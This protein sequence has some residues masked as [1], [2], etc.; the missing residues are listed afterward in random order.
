M[1]VDNWS[2]KLEKVLEDYKQKKLFKHGK[3]DC[4]VNAVHPFLLIVL[5][6][7]LSQRSCDRHKYFDGNGP[8]KKCQTPSDILLSAIRPYSRRIWTNGRR[9]A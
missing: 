1:R 4:V 9:E 3:N 2:S 8:T 5:R 7:R 6:R